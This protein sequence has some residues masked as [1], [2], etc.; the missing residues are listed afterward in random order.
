MRHDM[1]Y[2]ECIVSQRL[3]HRVNDKIILKGLFPTFDVECTGSHH[4]L[5]A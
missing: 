1:F 2:L 4:A 5:F 3:N